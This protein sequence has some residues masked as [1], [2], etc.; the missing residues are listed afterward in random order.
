MWLKYAECLNANG[1]LQQAV[2]AYKKVVESAPNHMG[3]RV[4]LS[5]LQQQLGRPD[6]ALSI[7]S[8]GKEIISLKNYLHQWELYSINMQLISKVVL[9]V[10]KIIYWIRATQIVHPKTAA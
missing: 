5:N 9:F 6:E 2:Q 10:I 4:S 8:N 3:A 7:L 1:E